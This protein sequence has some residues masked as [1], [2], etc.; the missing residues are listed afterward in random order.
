M[1][2]GT[3]IYKH[4]LLKPLSKPSNYRL[5]TPNPTTFPVTSSAPKT[6]HAMHQPGFGPWSTSRLESKIPAHPACD[7]FGLRKSGFRDQG[8]GIRLTSVLWTWALAPGAEN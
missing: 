6:R 2:P 8:L 1:S 5:Q 4:L 3:Y 7:F